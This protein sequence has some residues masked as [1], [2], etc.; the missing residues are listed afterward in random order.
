MKY[1]LIKNRSVLLTGCSTGIGRAAARMLKQRGWQV[2][3]TARK[4]EDLESLRSEGLEAVPMELAEAESVEAG[5]NTA[6]EICGGVLGALV[7]N[8]GYGQPGALEDISR[9]GLRRQFEVNVLGAQQL[10]NLCIPLFRKQEQGRIV[11]VSSMLGRIT[12]PF[13]GAYCASKY[14]LESLSDALRVELHGSGIAVSLIE[15]G[16]IHTRFGDNS[17][18][19]LEELDSARSPFHV[20]YHSQG[21][22]MRGRHGRH[23]RLALP[24]EAVAK[25][26]AHALESRRPK[27]RYKVTFPAYLGAGMRRFAPEGLLDRVFLKVWQRRASQ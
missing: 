9:D 13:M 15:P 6:L 2:V 17:I 14:A 18:D 8:A 24:P 3:A 25:K 19:K 26:I 22:R 20:H 10:A 12:L 7:N 21:E 5:F 1:P 11:N 27:I 4:E 16:P 23:D